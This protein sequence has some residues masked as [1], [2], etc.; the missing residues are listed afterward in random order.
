[1]IKKELKLLVPLRA[2]MSGTKIR[3]HPKAIKHK[4]QKEQI[5]QSK[6]WFPSGYMVESFLRFKYI[7]FSRESLT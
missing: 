3:E 2:R 4:S 7:S 6:R 1:M 5:T